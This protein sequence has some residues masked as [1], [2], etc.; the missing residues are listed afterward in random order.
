[1]SMNIAIIVGHLGRDPDIRTT[2]TGDKIANFSIATSE[3]WK[4]KATGERREETQWH[5]VVV[6]NPALAGIAEQ[7][8]KKGSRC[9]VTGMIK[10]RKYQDRDGITRKATEIVI[11][12]FK[13]ELTLL[14]QPQGAQR[15]EHGY[16][17]QRV[18]DSNGAG[19]N[20]YADQKARSAASRTVQGNSPARDNL[21]DDIPF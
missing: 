16:G 2:N 12:R 21:D 20:G 10:T 6:F 7:Y 11:G 4:D 14:G 15:D 19:S 1:M 8:L 13:G 9:G 3:S 18:K 17:Q 5:N